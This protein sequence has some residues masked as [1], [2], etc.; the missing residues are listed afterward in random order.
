VLRLIRWS[1]TSL[2]M[3]LVAA[4]GIVWMARA[5]PGGRAA[6]LIAA[7]AAHTGSTAAF[8][9]TAGTGGPF[10]L[11]ESNGRA[12]TDRSYRGRWMLVYFG[13]TY[14]PDVSPA[15]LQTISGV[16][17]ELG[18]KA[19]RVAPLFITVDPERDTPA[20]IGQY[21]ALFDQRLI[22]LTGTPSQIAAV[23]S[24]YHVESRQVREKGDSTYMVDYRSDVYLMDPDGNL[25]ALFRD[26]TTAPDMVGS[27]DAA[28]SQ[29][30]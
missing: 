21:V 18:D 2:V 16:L 17:D 22:G 30:K 24:A 23:E 1:A 20:A 29:Q 13:Y 12:V 25:K 3:V 6:G 19:P 14:S 28:I 8:G 7:I 9:R 26:G 4:W 10:S 5:D 27:I 15:M 11:V